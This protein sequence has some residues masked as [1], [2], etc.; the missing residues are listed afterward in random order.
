MRL[1]YYLTVS[2]F[3][4]SIQFTLPLDTRNTTDNKNTFEKQYRY[5]AYLLKYHKIVKLYFC[6]IWGIHFPK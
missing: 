2:D 4:N 1:I 6:Y 3:F 5:L